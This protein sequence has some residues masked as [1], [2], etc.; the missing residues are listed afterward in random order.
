MYVRAYAFEWVDTVAR[1][2]SVLLR[3]LT[4]IVSAANHPR[5]RYKSKVFIIQLAASVCRMR[6]YQLRL[7][8]V[9]L[10]ENHKELYK[11]AD[12]ANASVKYNI[13]AE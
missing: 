7:P 5:L 2:A 13:H 3:A 6:E 1:W 8:H 9:S 10:F 12:A 4:L 11:A